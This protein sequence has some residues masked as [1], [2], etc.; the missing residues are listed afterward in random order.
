MRAGKLDRR[1]T[2]QRATTA[3]NARNEQIETWSDLATV[4]AQQRPNRG[5]ERFAA[6]EVAGQSVMTFHIRYRRDLTVKD[7]ISYQGKVWDILDVREVGR[8]VVTEIDV[9]A[10]AEGTSA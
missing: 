7:R 8:N 1:I 5:Q 4:W 9:V 6:Q 10:R 2:I 3:A